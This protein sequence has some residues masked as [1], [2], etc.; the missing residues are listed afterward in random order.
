MSKGLITPMT[1]AVTKEK[2]EESLAQWKPVT[3]KE[4]IRMLHFISS[5]TKYSK[6]IKDACY[7][8]LQNS[9]ATSQNA[10]DPESGLEVV[11]VEPKT[12]VYK[13]SDATIA[14]EAKLEKLLLEVA[15]VKAQLKTEYEANGLDYEVDGTSYYKTK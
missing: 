13:E 4:S 2:F 10:V 15:D 1:T 7:Y 11:L 5:L 8:Y 14:L 12:K 6:N 9:T 3:K